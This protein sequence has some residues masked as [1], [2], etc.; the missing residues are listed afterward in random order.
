[1]KGNI[2]IIF[3]MW[4]EWSK[5]KIFLGYYFVIFIEVYRIKSVRFRGIVIVNFIIFDCLVRENYLI[6]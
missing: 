3:S 1:M 5:Y 4:F 2:Q 6:N